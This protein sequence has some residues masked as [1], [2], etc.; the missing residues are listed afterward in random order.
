MDNNIAYEFGTTGIGDRLTDI[1]VLYIIC[2]YLN[3][4]VHIYFNQVTSN[5]VAWSNNSYFDLS[6]F[7]FPEN[8][9]IIV[10]NNYDKPDNFNTYI[11]L[12]YSAST[13]C[14]Y[15]VYKFLKQFIPNLT[16]EEIISKW[17]N[18]AKEII[19]PSKIILD[20]IPDNIENA[21]GIHLRKTDKLSSESFNN[22][23]DYR[24]VSMTDEFSIIVNNLIKDI[25]DIILKEDEPS[26]LIVSEDNDW[27][28]YI[29]NIFKEYAQK[30]NKTINIININYDNPDNINNY[31]AVLD[32]FCLSKCKKIFQGVKTSNYSNIAAII[33]NNKLMN[34]SHLLKLSNILYTNIYRPV[35]N[36]NGKLEYDID[37][38]QTIL[39]NIPFI[40]S[41]INGVYK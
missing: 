6:L 30:N 26:F 10:K 18:Y 13:G 2:K 39:L 40:D 33:G 21:Y 35:I 41:N 20:K 23:T 31:S 34:Y 19:K 11:K 24:Y 29:T 4:K 5:D 28:E 38:I 27:K 32:L 9:N 16:F 8:N 15:N 14:P 17:G 3:Y 36:I 37:L 1:T 22:Y 7:D 12:P 25:Y